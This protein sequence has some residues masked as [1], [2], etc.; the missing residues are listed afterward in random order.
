MPLGSFQTVKQGWPWLNLS[1]A[2]GQYCD[3]IIAMRTFKQRE[4]GIGDLLGRRM[5]HSFFFQQRHRRIDAQQRTIF[6]RFSKA[7]GMKQQKIAWRKVQRTIG[8]SVSGSVSRNGRC[9]ASSSNS[10][11]PKE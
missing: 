3:V 7:I 9:P 6:S 5:L 2:E 8:K 11:T 1:D 4:Y 10:I